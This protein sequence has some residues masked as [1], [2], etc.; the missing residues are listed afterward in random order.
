MSKSVAYVKTTHAS[1]YLQQLCK[2]WSHRLSVTFTP[3]HGTVHFDH[4]TCILDAQPDVLVTVI[5]SDEPAM[6]DR[7]E[8]VVEDHLKRFAFREELI[9]AWTRPAE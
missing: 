4:A 8:T 5:E 7:L 3:E 6:L 9:F 2:H 1:K